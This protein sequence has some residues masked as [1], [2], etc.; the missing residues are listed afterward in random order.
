MIDLHCHLLPGIDDGAQTL[1]QAVEMASIAAADGCRV[2]VATPHQRRD[3]WDTSDP[4]RLAAT[5]AELAQKIPGLPELRL[6][7][8]VRVDSDLLS[9]LANPE[10]A[11]VLSLGGSRY[12]LLE[13]EPFGLGPDPVEVILE[14]IAEGWRPIVAHPEVI[15]FL[16]E[17]EDDL[18]ARL[19]EAGA[20]LQVTAMSVT[21]EFGR[22][23]KERVWDLLRA[24]W[25]HFVASDSHRPDWRPPGLSRARLA[26]ERE[27]GTE[28]A[29]AL[30]AGHAQAVLDDRTFENAAVS[31]PAVSARAM[32]RRLY[33][34]SRATR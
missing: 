29:E 17:N 12:L 4:R 13:L 26:I 16:W 3:E 33:D 32:P 2:I 19:V 30:T 8:E 9:D 11:G 25:V 22:G 20:L 14:L 10:R 6:G 5:L 7:G 24:G 31:A 28:I 1:M 15:P 18:L 23:A 27:L 21:G 34:V